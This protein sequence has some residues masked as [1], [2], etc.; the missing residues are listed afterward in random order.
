M[1]EPDDFDFR[2]ATPAGRLILRREVIRQGGTDAEIRAAL[3]HNLVER[4][5]WGSYVPTARPDPDDP[6]GDATSRYRRMIDAAV[7]TGGASRYLSHQSAAAV[8]DIPLLQPDLSTVHFVSRRSGRTSPG[9]VIHQTPIPD[10]QLTTVGGMTVTGIGRTVCDVARSGTLRQAVCALDAGLYAAR[11]RGV[12]VDLAEIAASLRRQH[13]VDTLRVALGFATDQSESVGESLSR[14][15]LAE[16]HIVPEP[17]LQV[18]IIVADGSVKRGDFGW[19]DR[20][21]RLRVVGEFDGRTKYRRQSAASGYRD[22]DDVVYDEKLREDEIRDCGIVVVRWT[23]AELRDPDALAAKVLR[24]L[25][26]AGI[27]C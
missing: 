24:A 25:R 5:W 2:V 10:S 3:R 22:A 14:Q 27:A 7:R 12:P 15:V 20:T 16:T 6:F 4:V 9:L 21:G 26:R 18:E 11:C 17:E 1:T 8:L 13:G 23:W 19:R